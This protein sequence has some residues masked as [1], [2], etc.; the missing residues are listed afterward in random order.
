M[1]VHLG[2]HLNFYAEDKQSWLELEV[3]SS[4]PLREIL[5]HLGIPAAE[6][7]LA[8]V[9]GAMADLESAQVCNED[10]VQLYPPVDGG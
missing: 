4:T 5:A 6:I 8:V 3:V 10:I 1:R 9:N 2:G 7:A